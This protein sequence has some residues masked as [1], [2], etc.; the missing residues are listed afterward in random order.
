M[1]LAD[2]R[3]KTDVPSTRC[4]WLATC[5]ALLALSWT[6]PGMAARCYVDATATGGDHGRTWI[7]AYTDLQSALHDG[8]CTEIWVA[9]GIYKPTTSTDRTVSFAVPSG[10]RV[11][12]GFVGNETNAEQRDPV[13]N[14]TVLSGD[15]AGDDVNTDGNFINET[16]D[17]IV[18]DNA[19]HVVV[20]NGR[21]VPIAW[22][23]VLDG[24][25]ITG[26]DSANNDP[27]ADHVNGGGLLCDARIEPGAKCSPTLSHLVMTGNRANLGGAMYFEGGDIAARLVDITFRGNLATETG[28]A[29]SIHVGYDKTPIL[30]NVTFVNNIAAVGGAINVEYT[31]PILTNVTFV[32]N[33]ATFGG[34]IYGQ[35]SHNASL[36]NVTFVDNHADITGGAMLLN[37]DTS[38]PPSNL[39]NVILWGNSAQQGNEIGLFYPTFGSDAAVVTLKHSIVQGGNAGIA[40]V[41]NT[42]DTSFSDGLG[43]LDADPMLGPLTNNGGFTQT[44][45][46]AIGSPAINATPCGIS[47]FFDQR[48]APRPGPTEAWDP[49]GCDIGAVERQGPQDGDLIFA[50]G[51]DS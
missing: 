33:Q 19:Y 38:A 16:S 27:A 20:M 40:R 8:G 18:G 51:F 25:T 50:D 36:T 7:D 26:G 43:N 21:T 44:L 46:P 23:T 11:Y 17:D 32:G 1:S 24:F 37:V 9:K 39:T 48:G 4:H 29:M 15:L 41:D 14:V 47:P 45:M 5:T 49:M 35:Y 42:V 10:L 34:A 12:G 2:H 3:N 22:D 13:V 30:T 6:M 28:G 31:S